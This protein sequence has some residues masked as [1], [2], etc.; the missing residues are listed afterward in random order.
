METPNATETTYQNVQP[1]DAKDIRFDGQLRS[2]T[3][4][5]GEMLKIDIKRG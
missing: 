5:M 1:A 3:Q 4:I 2:N